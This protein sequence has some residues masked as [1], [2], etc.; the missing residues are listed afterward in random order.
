MA[1]KV[2]KGTYE[3][4]DA[5]LNKLKPE[6]KNG[7]GGKNRRRL[8]GYLN[9]GNMTDRE[10][11]KLIHDNKYN[12]LGTEKDLEL[13]GKLVKWAE[14]ELGGKTEHTERTNRSQMDLGIENK[15]K[16]THTKWMDGVKPE[17][18][19][20]II[21]R[22]KPEVESMKMFEST[23]KLNEEISRSRKLM[24]INEAWEEKIIPEAWFTD[25]L[26]SLEQVSSMD[27]NKPNDIYYKLGHDV[28]LIYKP[29]ISKLLVNHFV[30]S[31]FKNFMEDSQIAEVIKNMV[32]QKY[33]I[34]IDEIKRM[35]TGTESTGIYE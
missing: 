3:I 25:L 7:G 8:I 4:P 10:M 20:N 2:L 35:I 9:S 34:Q 1:N 32:S 13:I 11:A 5:I 30:W 27:P 24:G 22:P 21:K 26:N 33:N 18:F 16:K 23:K 6:I 14:R 17:K 19:S 28:K 29:D 31:V 12:K 15:F